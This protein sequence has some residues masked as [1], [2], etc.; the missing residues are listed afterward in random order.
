MCLG[1]ERRR[2]TDS[3]Q[4]TRE[5]NL[6]PTRRHRNDR[7]T[8]ETRPFGGEVA[9]RTVFSG[10]ARR[11]LL[12][13]FG[14][15]YWP[16]SDIDLSA[17]CPAHNGI[18]TGCSK[19][20]APEISTFSGHSKYSMDLTE[21]SCTGSRRSVHPPYCALLRLSDVVTHLVVVHH[22]QFLRLPSTPKPQSQQRLRLSVLYD[23][24]RNSMIRTFLLRNVTHLKVYRTF[25][26]TD[27][28]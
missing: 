23:L 27:L 9:I 21:Q 24:V 11:H 20:S 13:V 25:R 3:F 28:S 15:F 22:D 4:M 5:E 8:C 16:V 26:R 12:K 18:S 17:R 10:P 6:S 2:W 7:V 1:D 19:S 14:L